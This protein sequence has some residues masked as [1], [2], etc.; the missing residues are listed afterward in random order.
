MITCKKKKKK[1]KK[2]KIELKPKNLK[3]ILTTISFE[4]VFERIE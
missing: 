2:K 4:F 1:K 3:H